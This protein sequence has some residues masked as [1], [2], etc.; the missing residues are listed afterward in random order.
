MSV[1]ALMC[2]KR[3]EVKVEFFEAGATKALHDNLTLPSR[4][5]HGGLVKDSC[6]LLA[7]MLTDDDYSVQASKAYNYARVVAGDGVIPALLDALKA[8]NGDP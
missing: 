8:H 1:G 3:E 2:V 5:G 7:R 4:C 6:M